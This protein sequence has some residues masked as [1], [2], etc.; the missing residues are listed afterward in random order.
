MA[1]PSTPHSPRQKV[2]AM[3]PRGINPELTGLWGPWTRLSSLNWEGLLSSPSACQTCEGLQGSVTRPPFSVT[4]SLRTQAVSWGGKIWLTG[5]R[6]LAF[7]KIVSVPSLWGEGL[8]LP[9]LGS[10]DGHVGS[11]ISLSIF[12]LW[13]I[14]EIFLSDFNNYKL[15]FKTAPFE[16]AFP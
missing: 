10:K 14:S 9:Y 15:K 2:N 8:A 13:V 6:T 4:L 5:S 1:S 16:L 7:K 3:T 11:S 12:I